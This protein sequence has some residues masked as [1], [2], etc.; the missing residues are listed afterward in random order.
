MHVDCLDFCSVNA[1][2]DKTRTRFSVE[3]CDQIIQW[4]HMSKYLSY[5]SDGYS[6]MF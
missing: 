5:Y 6:K 4:S 1:Q 3:Y 2:I